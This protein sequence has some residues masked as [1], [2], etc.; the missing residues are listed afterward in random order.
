M[1]KI[2]MRYWMLRRWMRNWKRK[3]VWVVI[4]EVEVVWQCGVVAIAAS[5]DTMYAFVR[6]MRKYPIYIVLNDFNW[7]LSLWWINWGKK[8]Y[9]MKKLTARLFWPL[10]C[11][12]RYRIYINVEI[13]TIIKVVKYINKYIY[14]SNDRAILEL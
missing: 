8:V 10:A 4:V 3:Y 6:R 2:R 7:L 11:H 13:Y 14:K 12:P 5:P 1:Y 9:S